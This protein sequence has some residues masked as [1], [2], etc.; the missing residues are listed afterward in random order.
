MNLKN[1]LSI[2]Q[3]AKDTA[4]VELATLLRTVI[5]TL[6]KGED[7]W[8]GDLWAFPFNKKINLICCDLAI[9][10]KLNIYDT[11][12]V[13]LVDEENLQMLLKQEW[14]RGYF[15]QHMPEFMVEQVIGLIA[16]GEDPKQAWKY[17][18]ETWIPEN[19]TAKHLLIL[20]GD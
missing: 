18:I 12:N 14:I 1:K 7:V 13:A 20:Q 10:S 6:S 3:I 4:Y 9:A 17:C 15:A 11:M 19:E 8:I 16:G 2:R 5:S